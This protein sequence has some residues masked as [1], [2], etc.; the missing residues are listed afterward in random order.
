MAQV[1]AFGPKGFQSRARAQPQ[2]QEINL[3]NFSG[4]LNLVDSELAI[5]TNF[6]KTLTNTHRDQDGS[7]SVRFGTSSKWDIAGTVSGNI[8]ASYFFN[9][10]IVLFTVAGEVC[11]I[12]P[13]TGTKTAIWNSTIAAALPGAPSGWSTGLTTIDVAEFDNELVC[14]NGT[15]K[16]ILISDTHVV[17]YLQEF[18]HWLKH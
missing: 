7:M 15:D 2:V 6:A 4:G 9:D 12:D 13:A 10:K 3:T 17:T 14:V 1:S 16:P 11:T 5:R 8:V 18:G